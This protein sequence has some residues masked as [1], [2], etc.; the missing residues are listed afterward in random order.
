MNLL[1]MIADLLAQGFIDLGLG[2]VSRI[3]NSINVIFSQ[4]EHDRRRAD[5]ERRHDQPK[6]F[7]SSDVRIA[8]VGD[9]LDCGGKRIGH[10]NAQSLFTEHAS[11]IEQPHQDAH[12]LFDG[13]P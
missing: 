1:P 6:P 9:G 13:R 12:R 3:R 11:R 8:V 10:N 5:Q 2:G 4:I 7:C